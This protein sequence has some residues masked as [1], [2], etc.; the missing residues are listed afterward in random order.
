MTKDTI[1][2]KGAGTMF[3]RLKDDKEATVIRNDTI[4]AAEIKKP[5]NWDRIA[6]IKELSPW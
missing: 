1:P 5:E 3:Y 4:A 2:M 6:K